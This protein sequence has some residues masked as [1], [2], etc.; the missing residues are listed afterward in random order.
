M[1][2]L[3]SLAM[4]VLCVIAIAGCTRA[5]STSADS[6]RKTRSSGIVVG[7][8]NFSESELL[9]QMYGQALG[10]RGFEV[11]ILDDGA[12]RELL[13]PALEQGVI[14]LVPEYLGTASS[15]LGD[16]ALERLPETT[17]RRLQETLAERGLQALMFAPAEN[18]N[19]VVV[20]SD[21]ATQYGLRTISDLAPVAEDLVFGGPPE[22][23]IRPLCLAGLESAYGLHFGSFQPLDA[24]GPLTVS[25]L[26]GGEVDVAL[27]FTTDAAI[28]ANGLVVLDD[29]RELQPA[30]NIV[31]VVS[32]ALVQRHG[33]ALV[34]ALNDVSERLTPQTLTELN[35][36]IAG[37]TSPRDAAQAWLSA[38]GLGASN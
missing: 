9:A 23:R 28:T 36:E 33:A 6:S 4:G 38:S 20:T 19:E 5:E 32:K 37:G 27:L 1:K 16:T 12:P 17:H 14:D 3:S 31:P 8:F 25:A 2:P 18:K 21:T 15:W 35:R 24:G 13:Q 10:A 26:S 30:E 7:A 11:Q 22:C 29:D 34:Q